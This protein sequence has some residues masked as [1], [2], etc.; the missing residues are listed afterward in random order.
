MLSC[1]ED[2]FASPSNLLKDIELD[3]TTVHRLIVGL[4]ARDDRL[5]LVSVVDEEGANGDS[6]QAHFSSRGEHILHVRRLVSVVGLF[7]R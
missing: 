5:A 2:L 4:G 3:F 7:A 6:F 1:L